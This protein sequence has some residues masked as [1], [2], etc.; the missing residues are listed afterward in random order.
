M[1][2]SLGDVVTDP[3]IGCCNDAEHLVF[4]F[5]FARE[6]RWCITVV[7]STTHAVMEVMYLGSTP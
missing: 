5:H 6:L 7:A 3:L 4:A 1:A 2:V